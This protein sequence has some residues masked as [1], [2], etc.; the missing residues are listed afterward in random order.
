MT[1]PGGPLPPLVVQPGEPLPAAPSK[2][3]GGKMVLIVL[4]VVAACG[5][6]L[7][8]ILAALSIYGVR[9]YMTNAKSAEATANVQRLAAGIQRCASEA[10]PSTGQPRGLPESSPAV[11][12]SLVAVRGAKYQSSPAEWSGGAYSC[13]AFRL[14]G[15]QYFQYRWELRTATS[16]AAV[17]VADLDGDGTIDVSAEQ[18]VTCA[19]GGAC[20]VGAFTSSKP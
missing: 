8:G 12:S 9:K 11:P 13:A 20:T 16:G 14:S 2:L 3:G 18:P 5:V 6:P 15:P 7:L 4:A 10:D 17:G 19:A 1:Q